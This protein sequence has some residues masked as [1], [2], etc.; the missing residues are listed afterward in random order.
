MQPTLT[1]AMV[2]EQAKAMGADLC[3]IASM[4]RFEGTPAQFDPRYIFPNAK[5]CIVLGFRIPRGYFRGIEEGTYF[6]SYAGMGYGNIN[7]IVS[8]LSLRYL[9][10]YIED[11]GWEAAPVPNL[12]LGN[13][14]KFET[15]KHAPEYSVPVRD[16]LPNPDILVD[17]RIC[18]YLAG[19]GQIGYSK[20]FLTPEFGPFQRFVILL[21]DAP[22]EPDPIFEGQ[23]CDRCM[24]CARA[25]TGGAISMTETESITVAGRKIEWGKLD[26]IKCS[27]AYMGAHRE[28][29]PFLPKGIDPDKLNES[30]YHGYAAYGTTNWTGYGS[31][32]G[33]NPPVEGARGCMRECYAHLEDRGVLT[34]SFHNRFREKGA[35]PWVITDEWRAE[36][37]RRIRQDVTGVVDNDE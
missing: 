33:N 31:A 8:P 16:G 15:Q 25:C 30:G 36:Y 13:S 4:D 12:F 37:E 5:S 29:N 9:C 23:L 17:Y 26:V 18:A 34:R 1:A 6:A 22:L 27:T 14:V 21:T 35:K 10:C 24:R 20:V 7:R 28:Y 19:L 3:G 11:F 32:D 2:K